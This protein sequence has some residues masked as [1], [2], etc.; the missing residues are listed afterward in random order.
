MLAFKDPD[1]TINAQRYSG[2]LQDHSTAIKRKHSSMLMRGVIELHDNV[3]LH[4][5]ESVGPSPNG[6][7]LSPCDI[8][9]WPHQESAKGTQMQVGQRCQGHGDA[10][11]PAVVQR[12]LCKGAPSAGVSI[13][14][15][16]QCPQGLFLTASTSLPRTIP[17]QVSFKEPHILKNKLG[18]HAAS[19][20]MS[21]QGNELIVILLQV[22]TGS[23]YDV[24]L[25]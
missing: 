19:N 20:S 25:I 9:I 15:L 2:N 5:L 16:P 1:I 17:T 3:H 24:N 11:I 6:P 13:G 10:V 14:C 12:T 8:H 18:L 23:K 7:D 4:V 21:V 22:K